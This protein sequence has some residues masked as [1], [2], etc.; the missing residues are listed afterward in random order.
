MLEVGMKWEASTTVK[1]SNT[2]VAYGSGGVDVFATPAMI[3]LMEKAALE[4]A[5]K[6]LPSGQTTVG[7]LVNVKHMAATPVGIKVTA[8]AELLE[9]DGRRLV[10]KVEA[11]DEK[12]IIGSGVHERYIITLDKFLNK[13]MDKCK[14]S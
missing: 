2:A 12:E 9:I 1:D 3:G 10:F 14:E 7:T 5:D 11:W 8:R 13:V 6:V 4:L